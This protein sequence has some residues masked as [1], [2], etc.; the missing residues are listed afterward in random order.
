MRWPMRLLAI[1]LVVVAPTVA[2]A[3]QTTYFVPDVPTDDPTGSGTV[4]FPW[5]VH[6]YKAGTY[7]ALP[8]FALPQGMQIDAIHKMDKPGHWLF[9]V[10]AT[11]ELP[12]GSGA[13]F[14]PADVVRFDGANYSV[15]LKG[16]AAGIPTGANVDA[17]F[18][19]GGDP[20]SL[21]LS[22][23]VPT[24]I[25]AATFEP[26]DLV[27]YG[28]GVFALFFD[29]SASGVGIAS[30]SN[31][32]AADESG[33]SPVLAFD[34][35]T[36]LAPSTGPPT[37]L[38][39]GIAGWDGVNYNLFDNLAGWPMSSEIAALSCQANP[40]RTY[41]LVNYPNPL[42]LGK[43][44]LTPGNIVLMWSP[45]CSAGAEDYGIYEGTLGNWY[46]HKQKQCVDA[47][48][49]LTEDIAPQ[50]ANSYY[51]VVPHNYAEEGAYGEDYVPTRIPAA[52]ERPQ[53]A[54]AFDRCVATQVV[55][56]C[57]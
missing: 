36:D 37:L 50:A 44:L 2:L 13:F 38:S 22:F 32:Q 51:V 17:V 46:S 4:F 52:I 9:S 41:E 10:E 31:T 55:T 29:A 21:I 34:I 1:V 3:Q 12:P 56:Q 8:V 57:P 48:G 24:T 5:D 53:P 7:A 18:L 25:A 11:V 43:S 54:N 33:G 23:D 35:P 39:G 19:L 14:E 28:A 30:S 45:S 27:R 40:G 20:G 26:A 47:G 15:F 42:R 6:A 16:S 49:D